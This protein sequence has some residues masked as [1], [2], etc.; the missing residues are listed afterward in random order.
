MS[1]IIDSVYWCRWAGIR[2]IYHWDQSSSAFLCVK[3]NDYGTEGYETRADDL[4]RVSPSR[5]SKTKA[6]CGCI[7]D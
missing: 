4:R 2:R 5:V 3:V 6:V 7:A 1:D